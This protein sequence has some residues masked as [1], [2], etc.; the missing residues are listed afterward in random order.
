MNHSVIALLIALSCLA[1]GCGP[2]LPGTT[3]SRP[4]WKTGFW[5][6]SAGTANATDGVGCPIDTLYT[7]IGQVDSYS[8]NSKSWEWL[9]QIPAATEYWALWRYEAPIGPMNS[10]IP[11]LVH[12]F[13]KRKSEAAAQGRKLV[14]IQL[15][16]D[17]ATGDLN[18]YASFLKK[19]RKALP[20]ETRISIT[21]LLD[22]FR[23]GT[24]IQAVLV[25]VN[26]FVPQFYDVGQS[27]P[28]HLQGIAKA[29]D[30]SRWGPIFNVFGIPYRIGISTFGRIQLRRGES[31]KFFR[32]L[33]PLDILENPLLTRI[34]TEQTHAGE[35]KI[36]FRVRQSLALNYWQLHPGNEIEWIMPMRES[37]IA[38]Y[39][40]AK[41]MGGFCS[42]AVFFR[43]PASE[44]TLV[45]NPAQLLGWIAHK[46][47]AAAPPTVTATEGDCAAL[48]CWD[49][50][51]RLS[52]RL[53]RQPVA[54]RISASGPLEYFLPDV[55]VK[56]RAA[57]SGPKTIRVDLP[58]YHGA[59]TLYL[60]RAMTKAKVHFSLEEVK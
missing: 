41:A 48:H 36:I 28:G 5:L 29:V 19:L 60:G 50:Q 33:T 22:W 46:E 6:W 16:Y 24:A 27:A 21:A 47:V 53:P 4:E 49:L 32:D 8:K 30:P 7:Q 31:V 14:G 10:Q 51:V 1:S 38:A 57:R 2:R 43:W 59:G 55:R 12:D 17:C 54:L 25:H 20:N 15:D 3:A 18:E 13:E 23:S 11:V 35:L 40:A 26:E 45:L 56:S 34:S 37:V 58:A 9:G 42:G 39:E 52:D 44:E